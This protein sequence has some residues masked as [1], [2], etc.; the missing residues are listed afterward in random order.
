MSRL[1]E[2]NLRLKKEKVKMIF[3]LYLCNYLSELI[4]AFF[5]FVK[6]DAQMLGA[7][8]EGLA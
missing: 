3:L 6:L 7:V 1:E 8:V 5:R 4:K 2:E